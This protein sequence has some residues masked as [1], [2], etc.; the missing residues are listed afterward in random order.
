MDW[1]TVELPR[2]TRFSNLQDML[3][4]SYMPAVPYALRQPTINGSYRMRSLGRCT[5]FEITADGH[6]IKRNRREI[7]NSEGEFYSVKYLR[8]GC[9]EFEQEGKRIKF[10]TG[11]I[12]VLD[13]CYPYSLE[14]E[15]SFA[16]SS[17]IIPRAL[18]NLHLANAR[19]AVGGLI[20]A[21]SSFSP[22]LRSHMNALINLENDNN[23]FYFSTLND[24]LCSLIAIAL[25]RASR[26]LESNNRCANQLRYQAV[27]EY[28]KLNLSDPDLSPARVAQACGISVRYL[29]K[30]FEPYG[31]T[32]GRWLLKKRLERCREQIADPRFADKK[33]S[34]IPYD[35]GFNN[36]SHFI[37]A[38]RQ[39]YGLSPRDY[40]KQARLQ[41]TS[42]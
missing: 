38:F 4:Q 5:I 37:R 17:F 3:N 2:H 31:C 29:H 16:V 42:D 41:S 40:R 21:E 14:F 12:S 34:L 18:L 35:W 10:Q 1:S 32:F 33:L 30:L 25:D 23:E 22:M 13:N 9:G 11:D 28:V 19:T 26:K 8:R 7:N 24:T 27:I 15:D 6:G 39:E 20:P 36:L